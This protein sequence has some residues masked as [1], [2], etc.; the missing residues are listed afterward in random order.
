MAEKNRRK[1]T[2]DARLSSA[3]AFVRENSVVAD[4]G[5]DHAYIPIYLIE[6][7]I[8]DFA[9]ASDINRGPLERARQ[10]AADHGVSDRMRFA[11]ADGLSGVEPEREGVRDI[12]ICGMG[13][14]LIASIIDAS[15]YPKKEGVRLI[16]QPMS[17]AAR[18][19]QYLSGAG[20]A[21]VGGALCRAQDKLYQCIVCEYTGKACSLSPA[22]LELG[23]ENI[24]AEASPL[25]FEMLANLIKKTERAIEGQRLGG[26][27]TARPEA[28]LSEL[29]TIKTKKENELK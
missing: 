7:G 4:I 6:Q 2:L 8:A 11:L 28:L 26:I 22:E 18:L 10:N 5:T 1:V 21:T 12:V 9:I 29:Y 20:F 3:A 13:G 19:R 15:E 27:D 17:Q 25:F 23:A 24:E 14:E 16:L